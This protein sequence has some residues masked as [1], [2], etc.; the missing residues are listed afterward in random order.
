MRQIIGASRIE[1][2]RSTRRLYM[3][4]PRTWTVIAVCSRES[5]D[6]TLID[7]DTSALF[8]LYRKER[9]YERVELVFSE[10]GRSCTREESS[11]RIEVHASV[12]EDIS[13]ELSIGDS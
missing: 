5:E 7:D 4:P 1:Y 2:I 11:E 13:D 6:S 10:I 3:D 12:E 9:E 8:E